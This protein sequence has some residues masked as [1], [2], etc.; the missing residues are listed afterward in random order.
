MITIEAAMAKAREV[1]N[2]ERLRWFYTAPGT[3]LYIGFTTTPDNHGVTVTPLCDDANAVVVIKP[4]ETLQHI[5]WLFADQAAGIALYQW[6]EPQTKLMNAF[7]GRVGDPLH[8]VVSFGIVQTLAALDQRQ[9]RIAGLL[10]TGL[11]L[12]LIYR[13]LTIVGLALATDVI[14][15]CSA[16]LQRLGNDPSQVRREIKRLA[17]LID[18]DVSAVRQAVPGL[19][20]FKTEQVK[21]LLRG[22]RVIANALG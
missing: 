6:Q 8:S 3:Q 7:V 22:M 13:I 4:D 1:T 5:H 9:K 16:M 11:P 21:L 12:T 20:Q 14:Y 19:E 17:E 18:T 2:N 15:L 10:A